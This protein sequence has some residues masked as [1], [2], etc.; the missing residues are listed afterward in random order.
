MSAEPEQILAEINALLAELPDTAADS[1]DL[2]DVDLDAIAARL[3]EAHEVLV[4]AL[5]AV[6][7]G[8]AGGSAGGTA[9]LRGTTPGMETPGM[10][11]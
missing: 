9:R 3:E 8:P 7:K 2:T 11:R 6:E 4:R 10:E 1:A 5:E